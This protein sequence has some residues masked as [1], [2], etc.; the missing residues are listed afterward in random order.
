MLVAHPG[1]LLGRLEVLDELVVAAQRP[2]HPR[3]RLAGTLV[4][5]A[6]TRVGVGPARREVDDALL[7]RGHDR[8]QIPL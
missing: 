2:D 1:W 8:V 4:I 7:V 3:P 6:L 5:L